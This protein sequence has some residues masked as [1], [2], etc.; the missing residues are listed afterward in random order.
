MIAKQTSTAWKSAQSLH[1][2]QPIDTGGDIQEGIE[3]G[4][5]QTLP[6][7]RVM[8]TRPR[9][10]ED[11][12]AAEKNVES[13]E[14]LPTNSLRNHWR[15][16]TVEAARRVQQL[17]RANPLDRRVSSVCYVQYIPT[18]YSII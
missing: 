17:V 5:R 12:F 7:I 3:R 18:A 10:G 8:P 6:N 14:I 15:W 1:V 13:G 9:L 4:V 2:R 11:H 16:A